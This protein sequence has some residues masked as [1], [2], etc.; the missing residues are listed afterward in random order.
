MWRA[1]TETEDDVLV[2]M[3]LGLCRDDPGPLPVDA[4]HMRETL[5]TLR[6]EPWRGRAVALVAGYVER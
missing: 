5:A 6:R 2:E 1:V 3:C 4:R